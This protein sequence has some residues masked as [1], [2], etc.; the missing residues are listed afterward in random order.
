MANRNDYN[1]YK[2]EYGK[3]KD[4]YYSP[5]SEEYKK[6]K[7]GS[8]KQKA[9][10][11]FRAFVVFLIISCVVVALVFGIIKLSSVIREKA[12]ANKGETTTE[13]TT[14]AEN[15]T[16]GSKYKKGTKCIVK[17]DE[18]T[19][20]NLRH[21]PT[22]DVSG[23][24]FIEDGTIVIIEEVS[25]DG[26]WAKTSNFDQNGWLYLKYLQIVEDKTEKEETTKAEKTTEKE[27]TTKPEKTTEEK[28]TK[29]EKT[30]EGKTQTDSSISSYAD[31]VKAF[32]EKGSGTVM[33]CKIKGSGSIYATY[34]PNPS[35]TKILYLVPG[36]SVKVVKVEGDYSKIVK[37]GYESSSTWVPNENLSFVSW[38]N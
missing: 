9:A 3:Y 27:K 36:E 38:G 24:R 14:I 4:N 32:K 5:G 15:T 23:Y 29:P 16:E 18:G 7:S 34:S 28:T 11:F 12:Q 22:Y 19:G 33:N 26:E 8:R 13:V 35:S 30:T 21:E 2:N 20:I 25:E 6:R 17:T 10:R 1:Y 37:K 31:A